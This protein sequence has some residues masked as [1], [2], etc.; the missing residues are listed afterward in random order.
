MYSV[1]VIT[2]VSECRAAWKEVIPRETIWDL[3]E[4]RQCFH[5]FYQR[6]L[7][8][9]VAEESGR[10]CGLLPLS[11]IEEADSYGYFPGEAWKGK[12]WIEQNRIPACGN[13][14][15]QT[16]LDLCPSPYHLRYLLPPDSGSENGGAIDEIGYLFF[17][18]RYEY[19]ME[20]YLGEFSRKSR[21]R[22]RQD[23][24]AF[25]KRGL[26]YRFDETAD[27]E[28]LVKLNQDRFGDDSYFADSRFTQS[29]RGLM[30]LLHERGWMRITT[31]LVE[32][33]IAAVDLGC[34]FNGV[35]TLLGGGTNGD[36]PGV[37]KIINIHHIRLA[38]ERK[39]RM[40][41]FLCGGFSWKTLFH[42]TPRP[43]YLL[44]GRSSPAGLPLSAG[45]EMNDHAS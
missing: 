27:F 15:R 20:N 6:P 41:D 45:E 35:Y 16:L 8:F 13:G 33:E 4:V 12:T 3:W 1:R 34:V 31:V 39:L 37:A 42:L 21:K 19:E 22:L 18:P 14:L 36:F 11:W 38:C 24:D 26:S 23:L 17:P 28:H 29:F 40:V 43:L 25:E 5:R 2:D 32:G 44:A 7:H 10:T 9:I 30:E